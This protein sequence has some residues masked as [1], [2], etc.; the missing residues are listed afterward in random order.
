MT[1][2]EDRLRSIVQEEVTS[3]FKSARLAF[4]LGFVDHLIVKCR[5]RIEASRGNARTY[6]PGFVH[7][8]EPWELTS[9]NGRQVAV[10]LGQIEGN[11][12]VGEFAYLAVLDDYLAST[13]LTAD[14]LTAL[15]DHLIVTRKAMDTGGDS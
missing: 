6:H 13:L 7:Y 11:A 10:G 2:T 9:A 3:V 15:I 14:E 4:E 1:V 12:V 5:D 8:T